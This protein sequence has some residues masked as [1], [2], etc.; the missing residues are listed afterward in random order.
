MGR[1]VQ[2]AHKSLRGK[3]VHKSQTIGAIVRGIEIL[4]VKLT[5]SCKPTNMCS[6]ETM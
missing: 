1:P 6:V 3:R 4:V 5:S 2:V